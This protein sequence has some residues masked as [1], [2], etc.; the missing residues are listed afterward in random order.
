MA[1]PVGD[2]EARGPVFLFVGF[3]FFFHLPPP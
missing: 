2:T 3:V 1:L